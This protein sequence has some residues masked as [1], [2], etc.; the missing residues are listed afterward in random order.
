MGVVGRRLHALAELDDPAGGRARGTGPRDPPA[1][2]R[3]R[4][5]WCASG[6]MPTSKSSFDG[7]EAWRIARAI[8]YNLVHAHYWL[9]G[10]AAL[11]LRRAGRCPLIP[12]VPH[13]RTAEEPRG[14]EARRSSSRRS[15]LEEEVRIVGAADRIVAA[16][17][18]ERAQ[19][20]A[21]YGAR[22]SQIATIPCGVDTEP[23]HARRSRRGTATAR[24]RRPAG[25]AVGGPHRADQRTRH[26]P[27]R[28]RAATDGRP[29]AAAA[30]RGWRGRRAD[31]RSRSVAGV[32]GSRGWRSSSPCGSSARSPR[33][34]CRTYYAASD[35]TVLPS[36]YESVRHGGPRGDACGAP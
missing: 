24:P 7:V 19:L 6:S 5:R 8:D 34:C 15:R 9:S 13:A 25:A 14:H 20:I 4:R 35:V 33:A 22:A 30:H 1:G 27:R 29:G 10:V 18:V 11:M 12:D 32:G 23:V 16:N 26:A 2:R 28:R 36:Y 3:T 17:V 21:D 31:E